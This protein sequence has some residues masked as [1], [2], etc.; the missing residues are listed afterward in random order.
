MKDEKVREMFLKTY[1][2]IVPGGDGWL[3][4]MIDQNGGRFGFSAIANHITKLE[5]EIKELRNPTRREPFVFCC[6][7]CPEGKSLSLTEEEFNKHVESCEYRPDRRLKS[8][9][10]ANAALL[11]SN[12]KLKADLAAR[13]EDLKYYAEDVKRLRA[14]HNEERNRWQ[15]TVDYYKKEISRLST[16][17]ALPPVGYCNE[18]YVGGSAVGDGNTYVRVWRKK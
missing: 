13:Q 3:E 9:L 1:S 14:Y 2:C 18:D 8:S 7:Y 16:P 4:R 5:E 6:V 17:L 15:S 11:E 12:D 10:A